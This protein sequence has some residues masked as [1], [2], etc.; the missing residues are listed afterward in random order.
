MI[1]PQYHFRKVGGHTRIWDVRKL[2]Q[3][4]E[5]LPVTLHA[6]SAIKEVD[7][8]YW[9]DATDDQATCR[10]VLEH[11]QQIAAADLAFPIILCA[12]GRIMDGMHRVMKAFGE[13]HDAITARQFA[14]T[15]DPDFIDIAPEDLS[16]ED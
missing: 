8:P 13:G 1:R 5:Q 16:Y 4:A 7:E 3:A 14:T 10:R 9:F 11:A 2:A 6:I 15:P 12:E